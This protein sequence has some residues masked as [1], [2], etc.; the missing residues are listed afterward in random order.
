MADPTAFEKVLEFHRVTGAAI[1][2]GV[3]W[4][5]GPKD[6][7]SLRINLIREELRELEEGLL[8]GDIGEVADA[9]GD[10]MYVVCGAAVAWGIELDD[11]FNEI[12]RSNMTKLNEDGTPVLREDG[13]VLKGPNYEP[14]SLGP[15]IERG[16][17][18]A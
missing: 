4:E 6:N 14:P 17:R 12:H 18:H 16:W 10:L 2:V 7:N 3:G 15:I 8:A 5:V 13:K 1:N 11:V 9:L